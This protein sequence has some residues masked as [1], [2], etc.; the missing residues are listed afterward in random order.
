MVSTV[1]ALQNS[2]GTEMTKAVRTKLPNRPSEV[3]ATEVNLHSNGTLGVRLVFTAQEGNLLTPRSAHCSFLGQ[4]PLIDDEDGDL[5]WSLTCDE[6][7]GF[8]DVGIDSRE[9]FID[10]G[11]RYKGSDLPPN[12]DGFVRISDPGTLENFIDE[13]N[14][15]VGTGIR[16]WTR[17]GYFSVITATTVGYGD[18][19]P[20]DD[21]ARVAAGLQAL[22]GVVIVGLFLNAV[23]QRKN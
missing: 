10:E 9:V 1:K 2:I 14:G 23:S 15:G 19:V 17:L 16:K 21:T 5:Y 22:F 18:I 13:S 20:R 4:N 12:D 11:K 6:K 8:D 3:R 7:A